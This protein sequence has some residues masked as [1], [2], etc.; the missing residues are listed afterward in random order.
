M[1]PVYFNRTQSSSFPKHIFL[2]TS[3]CQ[4]TI[5]NTSTP[6]WEGEYIWSAPSPS[7][8]LELRLA[9]DLMISFLVPFFSCNP[10]FHLRVEAFD[11]ISS[12]AQPQDLCKP[13]NCLLNYGTLS[14][15]SATA[16]TGSP[17]LRRSLASRSTSQENTGLVSTIPVAL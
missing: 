17:T 2:S 10:L 8:H 9:F 16:S 13:Y 6:I 4:H 15:M 12:S 5:K 7:N 14:R 11:K 3:T 1:S